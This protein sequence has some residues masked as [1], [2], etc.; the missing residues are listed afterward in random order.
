MD[1]PISFGVNPYR[2][3]NARLTAIT[4]KNAQTKYFSN[5]FMILLGHG[6]ASGVQKN[7]SIL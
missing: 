6:M 1:V 4:A 3:H 2:T 5:L 7:A